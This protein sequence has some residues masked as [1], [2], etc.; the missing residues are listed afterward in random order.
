MSASSLQ[1]LPGKKLTTGHAK[2]QAAGITPRM[3]LRMLDASPL[4]MQALVAAWPVPPRVYD[5][6]FLFGFGSET[7]EELPEAGENEA[8]ITYGGWSFEELWCNT[9]VVE[10][11]LVWP[12]D[13]S[14]KYGWSTE[15]LPSGIYRVRLPIPDSNRKTATQQDGLLLPGETG[16][17]VLQATALLAH[18]LKTGEDLLKGGW[19]RLP[20]QTAGDSRAG[21]LVYGGRLNLCGGFGDIAGG[22][23]WSGGASRISSEP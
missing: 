14:K 10:K 6:V 8:I 2:L 12:Q 17:I 11:N 19:L 20:H 5:P 9:V 18:R 4:Q 16:H 7:K 15:K 23:V 21:L 3:W 1:S 13:W 22:N